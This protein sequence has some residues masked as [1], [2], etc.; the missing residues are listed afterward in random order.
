MN[1]KLISEELVNRLLESAPGSSNVKM[2]YTIGYMQSV[3]ANLLLEYPAAA[4]KVWYK[5]E[6]LKNK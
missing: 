2:A 6:L 5:V 3:I 4:T 1:P